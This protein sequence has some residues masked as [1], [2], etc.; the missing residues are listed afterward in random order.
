MAQL[1]RVTINW[2]GF[3][4]A[5]GFTNMYF[6][7]AAGSVVDQAVVNAAVAK[8]DNWLSQFKSSLPS[9]VTVGVDPSIE[10]I[11][12]TNGVLQAFMTGTPA[13]AS[14]GTDTGTFS[15]ATGV[16][17][18]WYTGGIRNGR[19]VRGRSFIV[20]MGPTAYQTDG[21]IATA[22]LTGWRGAA[23]TLIANVDAARLAVWGRPTG[24]GATDGVAY[25]VISANM[26]DKVA[27]LTSRRD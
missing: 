17:T 15:A 3:V 21:T 26:N 1:A 14:A 12:S 18:S 2:T 22:K 6:S 7:P 20:P 5:P 8:V 4:G 9:A 13:A 10:V 25:D 24:P 23:N 27:I 16:V 11:E 19:R